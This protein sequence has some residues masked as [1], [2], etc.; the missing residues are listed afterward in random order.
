M[1]NTCGPESVA[2]YEAVKES[3]FPRIFLDGSWPKWKDA[4]SIHPMVVE[5]FEVES[6]AKGSTFG[7]APF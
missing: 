6:N 4:H 2:R 1:R 3:F 5:R 7:V